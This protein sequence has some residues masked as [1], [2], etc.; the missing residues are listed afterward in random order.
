MAITN[1]IRLEP[2]KTA[3][4]RHKKNSNTPNRT[5]IPL[6]MFLRQG[7]SADWPGTIYNGHPCWISQGFLYSRILFDTG[8]RNIRISATGPHKFPQVVA[9]VKEH[10]GPQTVTK[11]QWR[12]NS[13]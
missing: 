13:L 2:A 9:V 8:P 1:K 3:S 11:E 5:I 7:S 6:S 10:T 12:T 4:S